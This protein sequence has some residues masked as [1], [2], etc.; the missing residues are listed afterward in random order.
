MSP[1]K[2]V[3][4][5]LTRDMIIDTARTLFAQSGYQHVSMRKIAQALGYSHG[6]LYYHFQN[7]A[8]LFYAIVAKDFSLLNHL[9]IEIMN[10]QLTNTEK[11]KKILLRFIQFGL[12]YPNH[13]ELM[14]LTRNRDIQQHLQLAPA[15][16][17]EQFAQALSTL[18]DSRVTAQAIWSVFLAVHGFVSVHCRNEQTYE[19]V[20]GLAKTHVRFMLKG[21]G[22]EEEG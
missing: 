9:L 16:S 1:R 10:E 2:S 15:E 6:A 8:E 20:E 11:V 3:E 13:Y 7:K 19:E 18:C 12:D 17:Y 4:Q 14:F 21:L 5:E 22:I